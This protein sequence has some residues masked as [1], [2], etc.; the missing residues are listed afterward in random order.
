MLVDT[1]ESYSIKRLCIRILLISS[2]LLIPVVKNLSEITKISRTAE[3]SGG[4]AVIEDEIS[5]NSN[6]FIYNE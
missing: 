1:E 3:P 4:Y 2:F 6:G 5:N